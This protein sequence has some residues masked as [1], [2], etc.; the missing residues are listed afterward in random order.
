M[1]LRHSQSPTCTIYETHLSFDTAGVVVGVIFV[2]VVAVV[3]TV[4]C[5]WMKKGIVHV[6][7]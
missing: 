2:L 1:P 4:V 6:G 7:M 3:F 5:L